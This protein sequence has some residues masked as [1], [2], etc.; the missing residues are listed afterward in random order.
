MCGFWHVVRGIEHAE[1]ELGGEQGSELFVLH[2]RF[3]LAWPLGV[4]GCVCLFI[5]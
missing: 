2:E 4:A 3:L 5:Y 1:R